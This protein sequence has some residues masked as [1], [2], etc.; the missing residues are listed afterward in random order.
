MS[1]ATTIIQ[2]IGTHSKSD[3]IVLLFGKMLRNEIEEEFYS[4]QLETVKTIRRL[5]ESYL[6]A[7]NPLKHISDLKKMT[8]EMCEGL[9]SKQQCYD[10]VGYLYAGNDSKAVEMLVDHLFAEKVHE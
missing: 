10:M 7:K 2:M 3:S 6:R 5:L 8:Q 1:W 9:I 4:E